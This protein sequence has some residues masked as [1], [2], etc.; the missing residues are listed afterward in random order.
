MKKDS[1]LKSEILQF[2]K[3]PDFKEYTGAKNIRNLSDAQ[4]ILKVLNTGSTQV[5]EEIKQIEDD[6]KETPIKRD[7]PQGRANLQTLKS[8]GKVVKERGKAGGAGDG[9][10]AYSKLPISSR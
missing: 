3:D 8:L 4:S 6:S 7:P 2:L 9:G 1:A 5:I 10:G